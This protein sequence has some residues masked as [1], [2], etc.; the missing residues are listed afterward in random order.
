M[1]EEVR[2]SPNLSW[3]LLLI[4]LGCSF[5]QTE[6]T[7]SFINYLEKQKHLE[8]RKFT[9]NT[10]FFCTNGRTQNILRYFPRY[11]VFPPTYYVDLKTHSLH[12]IIVSPHQ[13]VES[14]P[15][16]GSWNKM[17]SNWKETS[18][19]STVLLCLPSKVITLFILSMK[20]QSTV[21]FICLFLQSLVPQNILYIK[22]NHYFLTL[23]ESPTPGSL[24][25]GWR[26]MRRTKWGFYF[27][28]LLCLFVVSHK[29]FLRPS[30]KWCHLIAT[31]KKFGVRQN[32]VFTLAPAFPECEV[33]GKLFSFP[34]ET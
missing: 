20:V 3:V 1:R 25:R 17:S 19:F 16:G 15:G 30:E 11:Q 14:I 4:Q 7:L 13:E 29:S 12:S 23:S 10:G 2:A 26:S 34:R 27:L 8:L 5:H 9:S 28:V 22:N 32:W 33:S 18:K 24:E 31:D 21:P 6:N